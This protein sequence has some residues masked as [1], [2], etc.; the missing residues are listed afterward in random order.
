[1]FRRGHSLLCRTHANVPEKSASKDLEN[2]NATLIEKSPQEVSVDGGLSA[3]AI[4]SDTLAASGRR[5][6]RRRRARLRLRNP[7][8][9]GKGRFAGR[10]ALV[11][12]MSPRDN[13]MMCTDVD[14]KR[15]RATECHVVHAPESDGCGALRTQRFNIFEGSGV[16][17]GTSVSLHVE[18]FMRWRAEDDVAERARILES[19]SEQR[20]NTDSEL[21]IG[22]TPLSSFLGSS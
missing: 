14:A 17:A 13:A 5:G 8:G 4:V 11:A 21:S 22:R 12:P 3:A 1:M 10:E 18:S 9:R 20:A 2:N 7:E 16:E 19:D 15:N 6:W